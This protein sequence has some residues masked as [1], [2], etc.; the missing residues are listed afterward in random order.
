MWAFSLPPLP[1]RREKEM[2]RIGVNVVLTGGSDG[3]HIPASTFVRFSVIVPF[4]WVI[5]YT[6]PLIS[7]QLRGNGCTLYVGELIN[8]NAEVKIKIQER[9]I[10]RP[11]INLQHASD[12]NF[13]ICILL[14]YFWLFFF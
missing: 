2:V 7:H 4:C 11:G 3:F 14:F 1:F 10:G 13:S 9:L 5:N 8:E 6:L 12:V